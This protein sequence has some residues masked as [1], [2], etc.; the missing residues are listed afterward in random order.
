MEIRDY[1]IIVLRRHG[2]IRRSRDADMLA[3]LVEIWLTDSEDLLLSKLFK[4]A[5]ERRG[6]KL[7]TLYGALR[8]LAF[9]MGRKDLAWYGSAFP[10][11]YSARSFFLAVVQ[12]VLE[13]ARSKDPPAFC[14]I[15]WG[16]GGAP[17]RDLPFRR[18]E[19]MQATG[20]L[21]VRVFTSRAQIPVEGATV[22]VAAPGEGGKWKLLSIQNTDSS[23]MIQ[24]V[25]IDAPA[26]GESTSP[27]GLPGDGEPFAICDVWVEQPGYAMIQMENVQIFPG[28]ETVQDIELV[29]LPQGLSSLQQRD[30]W[31]TPAQDL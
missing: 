19:T 29:P 14:R 11:R 15:G 18:Y 17:E 30:V 9:R 12:E 24:S 7:S 21:S 13:L 22:V 2:I 23:G 31:D 26:T 4:E 8:S 10:K 25:R 6:I 1:A 28:V 20:T 27:G 5:A 3:E 16:K